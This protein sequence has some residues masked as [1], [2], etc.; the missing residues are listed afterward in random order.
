M[1]WLV[2]AMALWLIACSGDAFISSRSDVDDA[3]AQ[4]VEGQ[5]QAA[6]DAYVAL[7]STNPRLA[8]NRGLA[9]FEL[10][11]Y[12]EAVAA[13][14]EMRE[15]KDAAMKARSYYHIGNV[16]ARKALDAEAAQ[17]TDEAL[18]A[19]KEAV[20]AYENTLLIDP[21]H[22]QAKH[23]LEIALFRVDPPCSLRN[24]ASEPDNTFAD[25]KTAELTQ[26]EAEDAA[27]GER[28]LEK[29]AWLCPGD[30]DWLTVALERGDRFTASAERKEG[31]DH[32]AAALELWK[33]DG[34]SKIGGP[35]GDKPVTELELIPVVEPGEYRVR[36]ANPQDDDFGVTVKLAVKPECRRTEDEHEPNDSVGAAKAVEA[37]KIE[38][39]RMCP[40]GHDWFAVNVGEGESLKVTAQ[41]KLMAGELKLEL[42]DAS[43]NVLGAGEKGE[44]D[45]V[46]ALAYGRPAGP[47]F[48][49][50]FGSDD[51]EAVY[52][53][54]A[55]VIPVCPKREDKH[56]E[57]DDIAGAKPLTPGDHEELQLCPGDP[58]YFHVAV[59]AGESIV[60]HLSAEPLV[61]TPQVE[62]LDASGK[63]VVGGF[64]LQ[65]G[66]LAMAL[67]PG[68]GAYYIK[69]DAEGVIQADSK[70]DLKI[71]I[72]PPCPEGNDQEETND[73]AEN[74]KTLEPPEQG[75]Q[76]GAGGP[77]GQPGQPQQP[78]KPKQKLLRICPG[79]QDWFR[80]PVTPE[81]PLMMAS[82]EFITRRA[83]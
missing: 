13:F 36:L 41:T 25:A 20:T 42:T 64:T 74:A 3:N 72:L 48:I 60:A 61:G 68:A 23:Q 81:T 7:Q 49:H 56:E 21:D 24:D 34:K 1:K 27:P 55:E 29:A 28:R 76:P 82:I 8:F 77:P 2:P 63:R 18:A 11:Q 33:P 80:I 39:L 71:Q 58:D 53:L 75:Q 62:V 19:W 66:K 73:T 51:V 14:D 46:V 37:G 40:G 26:A 69:V 70:Y 4:L 50:A 16:H 35:E 57:N 15:S 17:L 47:V 12:D 31:P 44:K 43:G 83:T 6:L 38:P 54:E 52:G 78:P 45:S 5:F 9:Q 67:D 59:T 22:E 79:D 65:G 30:E 32:A 10:K